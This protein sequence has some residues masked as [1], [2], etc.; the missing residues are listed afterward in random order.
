MYKIG[1]ATILLLER[2]HR[3][4][5][6]VIEVL[7]PAQWCQIYKLVLYKLAR[8]LCIDEFAIGW[9]ST[10]INWRGNGGL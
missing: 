10:V 5:R 6:D 9:Q 4:A 8:G 7:F 1:R 2:N 3:S